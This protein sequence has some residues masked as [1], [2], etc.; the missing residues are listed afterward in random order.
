MMA[1]LYRGTVSHVRTTP[2]RHAFVYPAAFVAIDLTTLAAFGAR[3][4]RLGYNR[5]AILRIDD[6]DYLT[7][8]AAPI[9]DK[10]AR[11][12]PGFDHR[13]TV[14]LTMP[15]GPWRGF[16]PISTY[17]AYDS[18]G[19]LVGLAAEVTNPHG[20]RHLYNVAPV[21]RPDGGFTA[22][23]AKALH[24]S[25]FHGVK[26][27][28]RFAGF[29]DA[30][31]AD[32]SVDLVLDGKV[33]IA[34]RLAGDGCDLTTAGAADLARV[35]LSGWLA[36]PRIYGQALRLRAKGLRPVMKPRPPASALRHGRDRR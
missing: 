30:D 7:A 6:R 19:T 12:M 28:Y 11:C 27:H 33:A 35:A 34:A 36:W 10:L 5:R 1:R 29:L 15:Y 18:A 26:G 2:R 21:A 14:L 32:L 17:H 4:W 22:E 9:A 23:A 31:R 8:D 16:N 3:S 24:V 13:R 25:P 20:E